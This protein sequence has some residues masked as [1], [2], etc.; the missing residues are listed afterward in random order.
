M[1]KILLILLAITLS[2]TILGCSKNTDNTQ[3]ETKEENI[4]K[5]TVEEKKTKKEKATTEK[6][7]DDSYLTDKEIERAYS[8]SSNYSERRI[9]ISGKVF[10]EPEYDGEYYY[11][12]MYADAVNDEKNTIVVTDKVDF[13]IKDGTYV[14]VDGIIYDNVEY[15]NMFGGTLSALAIASKNV[16]KSS[17]IECVSPTIKEIPVNI[18]IE[19]NGY[20][21]TL[22]KIEF[23]ESETRVYLK[24]NNNGSDEFH[25]EEYDIK[26]IQGSK[27][28]K[29]QNNYDADYPEI[30]TNLMSGV[31]TSGIICFPPI[32]MNS[33]FK[34]YCEGYSENWEENF[35]SYEFNIKP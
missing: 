26:L 14:N 2:A 32:D 35:E 8:N 31:E 11:F 28:F 23:S 13:D 12:Q 22:E 1:K 34:I 16:S 24:I 17:Y 30:Q 27:Q 29:T 7:A 5:N 25:F 9:R 33:K 10:G 18:P 20:K 3:N 15:E 19:Q 4:I 21:I 6:K